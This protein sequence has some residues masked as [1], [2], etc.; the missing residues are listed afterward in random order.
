MFV[1]LHKIACFW[2]SSY[3]LV[4]HLLFDSD[5]LFLQRPTLVHVIWFAGL[6]VR[7]CVYGSYHLSNRVLPCAFKRSTQWIY[8]EG[9]ESCQRNYNQR[10]A[11]PWCCNLCVP[12]VPKNLCF[13]FVLGNYKKSKKRARRRKVIQGHK[14]RLPLLQPSL[15]NA[16]HHSCIT[17]WSSV[18][19]LIGIVTQVQLQNNVRC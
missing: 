18:V 17:G 16:R 10:R 19:F 13:G 15:R 7:T 14:E 12:F 4:Y 8:S 2:R 5:P 3:N 6:I 9:I 11:V 1:E